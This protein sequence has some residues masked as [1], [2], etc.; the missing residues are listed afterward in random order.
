M[1]HAGQGAAADAAART[2]VVVGASSSLG[3]GIVRAL[4]APRATIICTHNTSAPTEADHVP[5]HRLDITD[6]PSV[7]AFFET[8]EKQHGAPHAVVVIAGV[9]IERPIMLLSVEEWRRVLDVNLSGSFACLQ[10]ASRAMMVRGSGRLVFVGSVAGRLGTPGQSAYAASKAGL[11]ALARVAAVELG[12]YGITVNVVAPG[13]IDSGMFRKVADK[14][15]SRILQ[16]IPS[17][18]LGVAEE[19]AATVRFLLSDEAAFIN[20]QTIVVDG[21][22]SIS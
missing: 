17:R 1:A 6:Q 22:L 10:A 12:R 18:R 13:A 15:V 8:I 5:H 11:E 7:A 14:A 2:I 20:G 4:A 16:R 9:L 3:Q 19:V 21:G